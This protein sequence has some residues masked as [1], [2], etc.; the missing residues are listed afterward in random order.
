MIWKA[1]NNSGSNEVL[2]K[3]PENIYK[4][5]DDLFAKLSKIDKVKT[6]DLVKYY[7]IIL[8]EYGPQKVATDFIDMIK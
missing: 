3:M 1:A 8:K 6:T 7:D 2:K 5:E 4:D